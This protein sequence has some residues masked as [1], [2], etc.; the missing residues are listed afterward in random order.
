MEKKTN[1]VH[2]Y[3]NVESLPLKRLVRVSFEICNQK[4]FNGKMKVFSAV[5][6]HALVERGR[7]SCGFWGFRPRRPLS[8]HC[9]RKVSIGD[10]EHEMVRF[11]GLDWIGLDWDRIRRELKICRSDLGFD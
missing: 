11:V 9:G 3:T 4:S 6:R 5:Y 10:V 1:G 7:S 2:I 8:G